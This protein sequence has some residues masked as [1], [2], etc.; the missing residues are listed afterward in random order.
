GSSLT[1]ATSSVS[2]QTVSSAEAARAVAA[3]QPI[4]KRDH[5]AFAKAKPSVSAYVSSG[6]TFTQVTY[7]IPVTVAVPGSAPIK[8]PRVVTVSTRSDTKKVTVYETN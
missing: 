6:I 4:I 8:V 3:A 2:T 7:T 1:T 5:P